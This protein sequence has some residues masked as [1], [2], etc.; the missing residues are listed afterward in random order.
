MIP[1][2]ITLGAVQRPQGAV[3]GCFKRIQISVTPRSQSS[4]AWGYVNLT[5][6]WIYGPVGVAWDEPTGILYRGRALCN[7]K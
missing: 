2:Q 7:A 4:L 1:K 5:G 3:Y 6:E